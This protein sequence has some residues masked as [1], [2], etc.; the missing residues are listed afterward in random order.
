MAQITDVCILLASSQEARKIQ[1]ESLSSRLALPICEHTDNLYK[2]HLVYTDYRLELHHNPHLLNFKVLPVAVDFLRKNRVHP[3]LC[4]TTTKDP[5]P[6]AV[7]VKPGVRPQIVDATAGLGMDAMHLAW[8]NCKVTLIE[9]SPIV[10]ALLQDG[11]ER[12]KENK[13]LCRLIDNNITLHLGDASEVIHSLSSPPH[14]VLLDP[15]YPTDSKSPRNRKEMRILRDVVGDDTDVDKLFATALQVAQNRL[16]IKRPKHA[17]P[18][19]T[20]PPPSHQIAM[21]SGRFDVYLVSHL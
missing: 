19:C 8:L 20:T 7:G 15:M 9:R 18:L 11:L 1:A 10:H 12:A 13:E 17:P 21:K 5:L 3:R 2:Y 4:S 16:V 14:T 6:K